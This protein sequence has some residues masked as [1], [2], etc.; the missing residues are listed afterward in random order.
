MDLTRRLMGPG[1]GALALI[2]LL[3]PPVVAQMRGGGGG[4]PTT[5]VAAPLDKV[6][7][8]TWAEYSIKRGSD[9]ARKLRY[10]L[11]GKDGGAFVIESKGE[12]GQGE[13]I[14][15]RT[16][17]AA[18]PTAEDAVKKVVTQWGDSDPMEM[19][20]GGMG[21]PGGPGGPGAGG[22]AAG[23]PAGGDRGGPGGGRMRGARF[24]KP[25]PKSLVGKESVKVAG[26]SFDAQHYKAEGPRGGIIN[27]WL[28]KDAGP[29]GLVK[30]EW[31]RPAG[32]DDAKVV[33]EL[34][35]KGKGAKPE[36]TKPAKP[37]DPEAMRA[38]FNR[39]GGPGGGQ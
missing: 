36:L 25:D 38:R 19:P 20:P 22:P 6:P 15:T 24:L 21:R 26:G 9:A 14:L 2:A 11:V 27:Y 7:M 12:T 31:D 18:D 16:V 3:S 4:M 28:A 17:V 32:E 13:K 10:S 5:P 30:L 33:V 29:F 34:A 35:A 39:G 23:S 37:F 8:G 1:L